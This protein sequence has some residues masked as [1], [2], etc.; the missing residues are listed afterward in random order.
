MDMLYAEYVTR[1]FATENTEG[2]EIFAKIAGNCISSVLDIS[3]LND[4]DS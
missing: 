3:R 1:I 2:T 4:R